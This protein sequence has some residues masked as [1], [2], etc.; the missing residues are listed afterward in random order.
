MGHTFNVETL[1]IADNVLWALE[2]LPDGSLLVT[3]RD[4]ELLRISKNGEPL[5][6]VQNLP[7]IWQ[8]G[9]GGLLDITLHPNFKKN[10]WVYLA[11]ASSRNGSKGHLRISRGKIKNN[12]WVDDQILFEAPREAHSRSTRH[13]GSRIV[14]RDGYMYFSVGDRGDRPSAQDLSLPNGK[15]FRLHDDG[16]IPDDNPFADTEDAL[17]GIWSYG[18]RNPQ[19]LVVEPGVG[20]IWEA[21]H[22]PRGGDEVNLIE[23]GVNYGWPVITYG[24]NYSGTTIT[25]LTA[26]P[27]MAQPKH[28]WVPSIAPA[29]MAYYGGEM[30][31][32]WKGKLLVGG[33]AIQELQLL[34]IEQDQVTKQDTILSNHG[35][36]R[37]ISVAPDGSILLIVTSDGKGH[38][39]K[40]TALD[41]E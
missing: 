22:G 28:Y 7:N 26:K 6:K 2:H 3:Q 40:L 25:D 20:R 19:S 4:G 41:K 29:G 5:A 13:F 21:E 23:R 14:F 35:R 33:L 39:M 24:K 17:A 12:R 37:D 11:Y 10:G 31:A 34:T 18:L 32:Q 8:H 27:G 1:H 38:I 36:I 15:V 9:Q 16:R 30:F